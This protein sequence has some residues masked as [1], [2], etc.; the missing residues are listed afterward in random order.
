MTTQLIAIIVDRSGSMFGK[1]V[2]TVGGLNSCIDELK[3]T[4]EEDVTIKV[5]LKLFDHEQI[6]IWDSQLLQNVE[7]FPISKFIPRGQTA[8]YDAMGDTIKYYLDMKELDNNIFDSCCIYVATDGYEN[9]SIKW[10]KSSLKE[11][12]R[13]AEELYNIK[14][15][16]L[17]AN[18][19]AILEASTIGIAPERAINYNENGESIEAVY[20]AAANSAVRTRSGQ[21]SGFIEA[22]RQ[23]SQPSTIYTPPPLTRDYGNLMP[24][25][26]H[27]LYTDSIHPP[28]PIVTPLWEQHKILDAA[29]FNK[30]DVV[31]AMLNENPNLINE[32]GGPSKRWT[33][34]HQASY[35]NNYS[36]VEKL[37]LK[38]A[39]KTIK[40]RD[41]KLASEITTNQEIINLLISDQNV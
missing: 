4:K 19:D 8:L 5:T 18:Q 38:G 31:E 11:L 3:A 6:I 32:E 39:D 30:W 23:A 15:M 28:S 35:N 26:S 10:N 16:Y 40:N 14:V 24:R 17:G 21:S 12:I 27:S 7:N 41:G 33:L 2:D 20:R 13:Q 22:E 29:K 36:M 9:A 25:R 1:E 37:L 34:L